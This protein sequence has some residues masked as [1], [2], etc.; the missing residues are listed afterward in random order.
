MNYL[1]DT[2]VISDFI[3]K[4]PNVLKHF[5][6]TSPKHIH[7]S[8]ITLMEIEYGLKFN[9]ERE[10]KIRPIWEMLLKH[11]QVVSFCPRCAAATASF[12]ANLRTSGLPIGPYDI[13]IAGTA[14]ANNL[15]VVTSNTNEF[16]R[17][18]EVSI[19]DWRHKPI[20]KT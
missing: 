11:I 15:I 9:P 20:P 7:I 6:N 12:R 16:K 18:P 3:K 10:K 13:L 4:V 5:E 19:E 14:F 17:V 2:C 8:V 1:L